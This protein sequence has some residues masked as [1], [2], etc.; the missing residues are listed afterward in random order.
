MVFG[1]WFSEHH[2]HSLSFLQG[3]FRQLCLSP[4]TIR[5][6]LL[7]P[8]WVR[9]GMANLPGCVYLFLYLSFIKHSVILQAI[10]TRPLVPACCHLLR[11]SSSWLLGS[12]DFLAGTCSS[13]PSC[14]A[15]LYTGLGSQMS[16]ETAWSRVPGLFSC[17]LG[18]T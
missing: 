18:E 17:H 1:A 3:V 12:R 13:F 10:F 8:P 6:R 16:S 4:Q 14:C 15:H 7:C 5:C 2:W 9:S 11:S